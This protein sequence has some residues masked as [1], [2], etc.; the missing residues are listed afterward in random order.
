MP[1]MAAPTHPSRCGIWNRPE[2][3]RNNPARNPAPNAATAHSTAS[4][5]LVTPTA[6]RATA[7]I[8]ALTRLTSNTRTPQ[9]RPHCH[10]RVSPYCPQRVRP[11]HQRVK[12]MF[13][14]PLRPNAHAHLPRRPEGQNTSEHRYAAAVRCST[15]FGSYIYDVLFSFPDVSS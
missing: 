15:L 9:R 2:A 5:Q 8:T 1:P 10:Q 3:Q 7:R 6:P 11:L 4:V 13:V 14:I 12:P